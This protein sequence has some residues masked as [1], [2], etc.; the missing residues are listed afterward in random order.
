MCI[1][2]NKLKHSEGMQGF[3][4]VYMIFGPIIVMNIIS[5]KGVG[6]KNYV[7]TEGDEFN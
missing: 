6:R 5:D 7:T 2:Y 4:K 1:N 3:T